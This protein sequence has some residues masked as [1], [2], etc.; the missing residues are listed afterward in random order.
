[1]TADSL[2][3]KSKEFTESHVNSCHM[4]MFFSYTMCILNLKDTQ[5]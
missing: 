1:M 4:T 2:Y 3:I 5:T